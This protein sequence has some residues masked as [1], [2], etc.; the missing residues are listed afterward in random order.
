VHLQDK[1]KEGSM[2]W[3]IV[4]IV[5]IAA[6]AAIAL[7]MMRRRRSERLQQRFGPEYD[8]VVA[9]RGDRREAESEL[10]ERFSRRSSFEVKDL[11]PAARKQYASRWKR[12][13][14]H[15]VDQPASAIA[16]ADALVIEVMEVRGYPVAGDFEQRAADISVDHPEFVEHYRTAHAISQRAT[17][18][19]AS[20]EDLRQAI[21][22]FR[23]LFVEL[24]GREE[25]QPTEAGR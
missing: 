8:R 7:A 19:S 24:L 16:E 14:Q 21:V 15:F 22:H 10:Q 3:I 5:V 6:A 18:S 2:V 9:D 25:R 13:Q 17:E 12:A 4:A 23:A 20:T 1:P 11:D